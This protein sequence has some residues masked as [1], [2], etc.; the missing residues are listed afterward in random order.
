MIRNGFKKHLNNFLKVTSLLYRPESFNSIIDKMRAI[1][2][3]EF[4]MVSL[5]LADFEFSYLSEYV[6]KNCHQVS[7]I[8][9]QQKKT[10]ITI[11]N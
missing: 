8:L 10:C 3:L 6:K 2:M 9:Q 5:G 7:F 11:K 1:P 4:D